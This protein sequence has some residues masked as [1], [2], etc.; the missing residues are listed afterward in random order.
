M[1][2]SCIKKMKKMKKKPNTFL[3][4]RKS[5]SSCLFTISVIPFMTLTLFRSGEKVMMMMMMMMDRFFKRKTA[6]NISSSLI[7]ADSG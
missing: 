3:T 1:S 7:I 2:N 6:K 4:F 5:K